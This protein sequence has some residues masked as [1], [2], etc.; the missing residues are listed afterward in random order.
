VFVGW[1]TYFAGGVPLPPPAPLP[2]LALG[3]SLILTGQLLSAA[4]FRKLG[5][6]GVFYGNRLGHELPWVTG[7]PFNVVRHPQY[8]GT[9]LSIWGLF[10]IMR[11]PHT[12]WCWLPL[13]ETIYYGLGA[14]Y[15]Q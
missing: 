3:G 5:N 8:V 11:F 15:E 1:W 7:F 2:V 14:R 10:L 6:A 4:V 9:V 12:D 13:L